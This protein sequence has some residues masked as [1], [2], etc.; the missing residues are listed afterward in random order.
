MKMV[1]WRHSQAFSQMFCCTRSSFEITNLQIKHK[2]ALAL[3][4]LTKVT[5]SVAKVAVHLS[6]DYVSF[7]VG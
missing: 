1:V 3:Q 7:P 4:K 6:P 2:S 5:V